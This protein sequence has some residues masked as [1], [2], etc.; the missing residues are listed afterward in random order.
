MLNAFDSHLRTLASASNGQFREEVRK[1]VNGKF[2]DDQVATLKEFIFLLPTTLK[3]FSRYWNRKSTPPDAKR[4]SGFIMTYVYQPRDFLP[5]ESIGLFGYLDDAYMV[6]ATYLKIQEHFLA[7]WHEKTPE[8][9]ELVSRAQKLISAPRL[10]VPEV[11]E[12]IDRVLDKLVLG[13]QAEF[14]KMIAELSK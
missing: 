8:E 12:R 14:E 1:R 13:D 5:E 3:L 6:V 7:D 9:L 10:V 11:T 2:T 4:L